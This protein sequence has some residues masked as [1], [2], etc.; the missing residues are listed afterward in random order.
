MLYYDEL[1][2][3][4][5]ALGRVEI[6][7]RTYLGFPIPLVHIG[8]GR[9]DTLLVG[10]VH[11]REHITTDLLIE[12]LSRERFNVDCIPTLNIDGVMMCLYGIEWLENTA[13]KK[14]LYGVNKGSKDFSM[15]KA[16][17]RAVDINVNFDAGWGTGASN[18]RYPSYANYIGKEP[19]SEPETRAAANVLRDGKYSQV[20]CYHSKGEIIYWGYGENFLHYAEAES[21]ANFLGY[22]IM[23]AKS[24]AG[25]MKDYFD[26]ISSGL[27]LTVEI[28]EDKF[29]HPY[30]K[31]ELVNLVKKHEGSI[32]LLYD[33]GKRIAEKIY[34]GGA[35]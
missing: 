3:K 20:V 19:E 8:D 9:A 2:E 22:G 24:S 16:N 12:L 26:T 32:K 25:G 35:R 11:A 28:G 29:P 31:S 5:N 18:V 23:T 27:G 6:I 1:M 7:G 10:S 30:P 15:W 14:Y 34:G 21:Y 4:C 33:N 13:L 17:A